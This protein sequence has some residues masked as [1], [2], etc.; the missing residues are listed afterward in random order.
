MSPQYTIGQL[1]RAVAVPTSTVRYY[2]RSGLLQPDGRTEGNY[3]FYGSAALDRLRFILA[4]KANGFTLD[5]VQVLL[6]FR[7]GR[8][9]PCTEVQ[10]LIEERLSHLETRLE[11]LHHVRDVL[12]ASLDQCRSVESGDGCRTMDN[13]NVTASPQPDLDSDSE[14]S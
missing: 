11:Q 13:L 2:E 4:A 3:R 7:A 1:A 9:A 6:D 5:D 8:K 14:E 10:N 12:H